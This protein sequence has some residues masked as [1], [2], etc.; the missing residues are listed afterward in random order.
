MKLR[1]KNLFLAALA[2]NADRFDDMMRHMQAVV[3]DGPQLVQ[4]E[5]N[6]LSVAFK[7]SIG[8]RR[9]ALQVAQRLAKDE[10]RAN[11]RTS[12]HYAEEYCKQVVDE[13]ETILATSLCL[14]ESLLIPAAVDLESLVFYLKMK[15]DHYRY[16]A[17]FRHGATS[18]YAC[19]RARQGYGEA[20]W[21][22]MKLPVTHPLRLSVA[23]NLS[24]FLHEQ[25]TLDHHPGAVR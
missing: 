17:H 25:M 14:L 4:D 2:E 15:S 19:E 3:L 13:L 8:R 10:T 24:V 21:L 5:R 16:L 9:F 11:S 12:A 7:N 23:L 6:L 20:E 18:D 1:Q 22:A